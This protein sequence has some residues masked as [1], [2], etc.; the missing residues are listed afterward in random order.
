MEIKTESNANLKRRILDDLANGT[1][2][3]ET[4]ANLK[5]SQDTFVS[6][7]DDPE[8]DAS[9]RA[10]QSRILPNDFAEAKLKRLFERG[11]ADSERY[12]EKITP[13][14]AMQIA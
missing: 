8:F 6:F 10:I 4:L 5:V 14:T 11:E 9:I 7:R 2:L 12:V 13:T 3:K 1:M